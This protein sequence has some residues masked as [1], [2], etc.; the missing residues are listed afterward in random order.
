MNRIVKVS[1]LSM[2]LFVFSNSTYA[3]IQDVPYEERPELAE[4][5]DR[6][7]PEERMNKK[8]EKMKAHLVLTDEQVNQVKSIMLEQKEVV[9]QVKERNRE[10]RKRLSQE[11]DN[12]LS[13]VLSEVQFQK[14]K[15]AK[16]KRKQKM[17]MKRMKRKFKEEGK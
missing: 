3:Q 5:Q 7:S 14:F 17:K 12:R 16:E 15:E 11:M 4:G 6:P 1:M 2:A 8:L 9:Q 10:E 13:Q